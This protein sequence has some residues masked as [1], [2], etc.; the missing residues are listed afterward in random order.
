M[1]TDPKKGGQLRH[2]SQPD[3]WGTEMLAYLRDH[4]VDFERWRHEQLAR[5]DEEYRSYRRERFC[6]DFERWRSEREGRRALEREQKTGRVEEPREPAIAMPLRSHEMPPGG[7]T[8]E[9]DADAPRHKAA[10]QQYRSDAGPAW[11]YDR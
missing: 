8:I 1:Y 5:L 9:P 3:A 2:D 11:A 6:D 4:D 10:L 7:A